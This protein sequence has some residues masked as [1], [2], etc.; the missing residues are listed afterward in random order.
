MAGTKF[1]TLVYVGLK[2][3]YNVISYL[4]RADGK[5]EIPA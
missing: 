1:K 5:K 3:R 4:L 2:I